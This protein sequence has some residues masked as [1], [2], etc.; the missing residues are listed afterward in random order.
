[1]IKRSFKRNFSVKWNP[2]SIWK[3]LSGASWN[4]PHIFLAHFKENILNGCFIKFELAKRV[5]IL[6]FDVTLLDSASC[7]SYLIKF[8][9]EA[10]RISRFWLKIVLFC[11]THDWNIFHFH[12][13][14]SRKKKHAVSHFKLKVNIEKPMNT[15][16]SFNFWLILLVYHVPIS[17]MILNDILNNA[18]IFMGLHFFWFGEKAT[19]KYANW[20]ICSI[21][22]RNSYWAEKKENNWRKWGD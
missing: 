8:E 19:I 12:Q 20:N 13:F 17:R 18:V 1:M 3:G 10:C 5:L 4:I 16:R 2:T 14:H 21:L 9:V 11:N 22:P 6:L 7:F 15:S